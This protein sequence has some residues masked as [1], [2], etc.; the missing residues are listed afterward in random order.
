MFLYK[1]LNSSPIIDCYCM[2]AAPKLE[3]FKDHGGV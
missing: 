1:A 2:G 3:S